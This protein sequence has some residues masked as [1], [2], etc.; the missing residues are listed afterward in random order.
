M[1][2][3]HLD[4]LALLEALPRRMSH[5]VLPWAQRTP[6][7]PA[8]VEGTRT[9]S[10][11]QLASAIAETEEWLR[12]AG[13]RPGDRVM[14]LG[15][16]SITL[17]VVVLAIGGVDAW[18][19]VANARISERE[20]DSIRAHSGSRLVLCTSSTSCEATRHAERLG[21]RNQ[22]I[23]GLGSVAVGAL[24]TDA[25]AEPVL[26]RSL[27]AGWRTY[28]YVRYDRYAQ[29][30]DAQPPQRHVHCCSRRNVEEHY[31]R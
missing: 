10:Y 17:A 21:L 24:A 13:V 11:A 29:R 16:N 18:P 6:N 30:G 4:P 22:V 23:S 12:G 7:A 9:L 15:E 1:L 28:L 25:V 26:R 14:L 3:T 8:L 27:P 31:A 2:L 5:V 19:L 20:V